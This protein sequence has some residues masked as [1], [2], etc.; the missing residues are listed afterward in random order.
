MKEDRVF[1]TE[2]ERAKGI[3]IDGPDS[4]DLDDAIYLE[5]DG[6]GWILYVSIA[7]V[8]SGVPKG[9]EL[10]KEAYKRGFTRYFTDGNDPMLPRELSEDKLSL[11][12]GQERNTVTVSIPLSRTLE[13]GKYM[14]RPT[15]LTSQ[16]KLSYQYVD[17]ILG[18]PE[19][20]FHEM[21]KQCAYISQQLLSR[22]REKGALTFSDISSGWAITEEGYVY[23]LEPDEFRIA[24]LIIQEFM[25]LTNQL[26]AGFFL[27][28]EAPVLFRN[29]KASEHISNRQLI[30]NE[31][32]NIMAQPALSIDSAIELQKRLTTMINRATYGPELEGHYGLNLPAYLHFTS[33][34]RRY[35]DLVN[36]RILFA[37]LKGEDSPYSFDELKE[38]GEHLTKRQEEL[39]REEAKELIKNIEQHAKF[40]IRRNQYDRLIADDFYYVIRAAAQ[41]NMMTDA[42]AQ[43]IIKRSTKNKLWPKDAYFLLFETNQTTNLWLLVKKVDYP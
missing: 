6:S 14:M 7:N 30:I 17:V 9:S 12:E 27:E 18:K 2:R 3:T 43:E 41:E 26:V 36:Q 28:R 24:N 25:I 8:D 34:I 35:A 4:K 10:D 29:H 38:M 31:L 13:V 5:K 19:H 11:L 42:L 20:E 32:N 21:L 1:Q 40:F 39:R 15:R 23:K 16:A 33:P 22:R 37:L